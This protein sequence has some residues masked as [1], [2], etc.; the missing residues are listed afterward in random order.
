MDL[1]YKCAFPD[2]LV[3]DVVD[4]I[5]QF[6]YR[7]TAQEIDDRIRIC[8]NTRFM[9]IPIAWLAFY[10]KNYIMDWDIVFD[11][12]I[13][14]II[15]IEN[16]SETC[17]ILNWSF[18]KHRTSVSNTL[19]RR[20]TKKYVVHT[21]RNWRFTRNVKHLYEIVNL[22]WLAL[23]NEFTLTKQSYLTYSLPR[24]RSLTH[25]DVSKLTNYYRNGSQL[26]A[27]VIPTGVFHKSV[28]DFLMLL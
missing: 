5:T 17:N 19:V 23:T 27:L 14:S 2:I 24:I 26:P 7:K 25:I 22:V 12:S 28:V 15:D 16:I 3:T 9:P 13:Q 20:Y 8:R 10:D 1:S 4:I 18:M 11:F 21:L 6:A